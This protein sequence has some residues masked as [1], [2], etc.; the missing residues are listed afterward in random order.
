MCYKYKQKMAFIRNPMK[1]IHRLILQR[2][3]CMLRDGASAGSDSKMRCFEFAD[4][5]AGHL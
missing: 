1:S 2:G 3:F 5:I 4:R